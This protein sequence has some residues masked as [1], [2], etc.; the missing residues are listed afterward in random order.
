V[1]IFQ[2]SGNEIQLR[3]NIGGAVSWKSP[4]SWDL[5]RGCPYHVPIGLERQRHRVE[6]AR[7]PSA[8]ASHRRDKRWELPGSRPAARADI[9]RQ[10]WPHY[11]QRAQGRVSGTEVQVCHTATNR[12]LNWLSTWILRAANLPIWSMKASARSSIKRSMWRLTCHEL[13]QIGHRSSRWPA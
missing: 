11:R 8:S 6:I 13:A 2:P 5:C 10:T 3:K 7:S 9:G 12:K 1:A 4:L